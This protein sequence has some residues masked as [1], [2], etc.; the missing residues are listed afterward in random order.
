MCM[1]A[2]SI[3]DRPRCLRCCA[4]YFWPTMKQ[5]VRKILA[6]CPAC[7]LNKA[8][9]NTAHGLFSGMPVQAPRARW[10]VDFQGQ[11]KSLTGETEAL[12]LIDPTSRYVVMR[13]PLGSNR[14]LIGLCLRSAPPTFSTPMLP[15]SS[16]LLR[17]TCWPKRWGSAQP[18]RWVTMPAAT[19]Q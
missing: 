18:P 11:G 19:G 14:S 9:Q 17:W 10:C 4:S 16:C 1:S 13:Q 5:V 8:R 12:A 2:C 6:N 15:R 3:L 7:E